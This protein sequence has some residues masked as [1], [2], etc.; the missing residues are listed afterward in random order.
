M[1]DQKAVGTNGKGAT[2]FGRN[3]S[4]FAHDVATLA[5][6]QLR[7]VGVDVRDASRTAGPAAAFL[8]SAIVLG[9]GAA[10]VLLAALSFL[11]VEAAGWSYAGAFGLVAVLSVAA[12]GVV[13]SIGWR[14][15]TSAIG[16]LQRS[17]DELIETVRWIK[18]SLKSS[19][20]SAE[21]NEVHSSQEHV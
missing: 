16:T 11:L 2:R 6:L 4:G 19:S 21:L 18:E 5:E 17:R 20:T 1:V 13:G 12:A 9:L 3:L 15:L 8:G 10:P 14:R 7:L